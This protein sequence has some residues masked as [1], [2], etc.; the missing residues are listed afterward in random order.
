ML[1]NSR[2]IILD[3]DIGNDIDDSWAL[4]LLLLMPE[5]QPELLLTSSGN[6]CYRTEVLKHFLLRT[7]HCNFPVGTGIFRPDQDVPETLHGLLNAASKEKY[8]GPV[9]DDG[10]SEA[11]RLIRSGTVRDIVGIGPMTNLAEICR[12]CPEEIKECSLT[13]MCGS[14][15]K[16]LNDIPG[17]IAEYNIVVDIP[18]AQEVFR[19]PWKR[20]TISPLDHCGSLI[21]EG[22]LYQRFLHCQTPEAT[23]LRQEYHHWLADRDLDTACIAYRSSILFD[24]AAVYLAATDNFTIFENRKLEIDSSGMLQ[25]TENAHVVRLA[26]SWSDK[27]TFLQ[28]VTDTLTRCC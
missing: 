3:T 21:L 27:Q 13:A 24:T 20:L 4:A 10:I 7:G 26:L 2:K 23:E 9:F 16:Q 28:F 14:W 8:P 18:A 6:T 5:L 11:I 15:Q 22:E 12:Q 25:E 1:Q 17:R 19:A